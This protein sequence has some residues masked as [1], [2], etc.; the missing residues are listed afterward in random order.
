MP[1]GKYTY[2]GI[3]IDTTGRRILDEVSKLDTFWVIV[4]CQPFFA[5][6]SHS[7]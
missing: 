6:P 5:I 3:D 4:N 7:I 1:E 2:I